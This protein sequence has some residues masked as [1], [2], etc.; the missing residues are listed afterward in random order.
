ML[1]TNAYVGGGDSYARV[2]AP[3]LKDCAILRLAQVPAPAAELV[4]SPLRATA[5]TTVPASTLARG[6]ISRER[7]SDE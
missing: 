3:P 4:T 1:G 7:N 5:S 6:P 2:T